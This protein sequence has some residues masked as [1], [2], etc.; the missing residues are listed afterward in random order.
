MAVRRL[1]NKWWVDIRHDFTRYRKKSP[2][3]TREGALLYEATL[4]KRLAAGEP[5]VAPKQE[6]GRTFAEFAREWFETYVK[7]NNKLSEQ[8]SKAYILSAHLV[9]C[10]GHLLLRDLNTRHF[11]LLKGKMSEAG[12][13]AKTMNNV[14][15]VLHRCLACAVDWG[16]LAQAPRSTWL[17]CQPTP[18]RFLG[19]EE[20]E[21]LL[22]ATT[23]EWRL[24]IL[25]ALETG[26]RWGEIA[27]LRW[28]S[29]DF[30]GRQLTV[31]RALSREVLSST[32]T[33][34]VRHVP[35]PE[36]LVEI[37]RGTPTRTGF[38]FGS[39]PESPMN[40]RCAR[41]ALRNTCKRA[42]LPMFGWHVLR[43]TYASTLARAGVPL[44][45]IQKVLGHSTPLMT[46]RYAHLAP[47]SL[48]EAA[49]VFDRMFSAPGQPVGTE[50]ARSLPQLA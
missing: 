44:Y 19:P 50:P 43:H 4:R 35:V 25:L 36:D 47:D 29:I 23:S 41:T 45:T 12:L 42:G 38:V 10:L 24:P 22:A 17:K 39:A 27:A 46:Q 13:S 30:H 7:V 11:E 18:P 1:R 33:H 15:A 37:L 49:A 28:E 8:R 9:P 2:L 6:N 48:R 21:R 5:V 32:K 16:Q 14:L 31:E 26:L 3:N 34:Q 40:Y 20:Q